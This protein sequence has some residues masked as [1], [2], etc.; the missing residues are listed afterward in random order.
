MSGEAKVRGLGFLS[1]NAA[2]TGPV[3]VVETGNASPVS[4]NK[5]WKGQT[6]NDIIMR[7]NSAGTIPEIYADLSSATAATINALRQAFQIQKLYERDARGG[8]RYT[9]IIRAHFGVTS[10]DA[11]LQRPEYLGGGSTPV[12]S[13]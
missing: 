13:G 4:Y 2:S 12:N 8:T 5:Y 10:P 1:G 3:N 11:R 9:E 6:A 7:G